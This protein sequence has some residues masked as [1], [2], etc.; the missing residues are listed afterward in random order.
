[1][2][3][4]NEDDKVVWSGPA[5]LSNRIFIVTMDEVVRITFAEQAGPDDDPIFRTAVA[6]TAPTARSFLA[7]L[8][9]VLNPD[10]THE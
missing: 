10:K 7:L 9:N 4:N 5:Y 1:M 2:S 8:Q 6:L 3:D